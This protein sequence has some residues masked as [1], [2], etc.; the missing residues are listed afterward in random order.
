M[1][2]DNLLPVTNSKVKKSLLISYACICL[3][4]FILVGFYRTNSDAFERSNRDWDVFFTEEKSLPLL[5]AQAIMARWC[6]YTLYNAI[7][8]I[9]TKQNMLFKSIL[10]VPIVEINLLCDLINYFF[11]AIKK[12]PSAIKDICAHYVLQPIKKLPLAVKNTCTSDEVVLA[13]FGMIYF[14]AIFILNTQKFLE[15]SN[16]LGQNSL[17]TT[18]DH[19]SSESFSQ[20]R[21]Y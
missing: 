19:S 8:N 15:R 3:S 1:K 10:I 9:L 12:Y 5:I 6:L 17:P 2:T 16:Q 14:T 18:D 20:I 4:V 21:P 13:L 11:R 7:E